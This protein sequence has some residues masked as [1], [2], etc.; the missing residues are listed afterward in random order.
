VIV[1]GGI[2]GLSAAVRLSQAGLAVTLLEASQLGGAASTRNQ[3]WLH[4]GAFYAREAPEY[5]RICHAALQQTLKFCPDC[6]EHGVP[7]MA[8]LFSRPETLVRSWTHA[9]HA[10]GIPQSE[11]PLE[12]VF[13]A[14]PGVA[15]NRV[16]HAFKLPDRAIRPD[17]LVAHLAATAQNAGVEIRAG[18]PVKRLLREGSRIEGVATAGGEEIAARMV[19]LAAGSTGFAMSAEFQSQ[20]AGSQPEVEL[21]TLKA[22]LVSFE[23]EVG[24]LPFCVPDADGFNHL[25]HPPASVFGTGRWEKA[26]HADDR[27]DPRQIELLRRRVRDFFPGL[28][29]DVLA[30]EWAGT[31]MQALQ[32]D[33]VTPGGALWPAV[34][35]HS[36]HAPHVENLLSIYSG[37]ATLWTR[38]AEQTRQAVLTKLDTTPADTAHPPWADR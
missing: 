2:S 9:W 32:V 21:M 22:H 23:Q 36:R 1:G 12:E 35:D 33:Q 27:V 4:S 31:M 17:V 30:H 11:M 24:R 28:S 25:P 20:H 10:A 5:A 29:A 26:S 13:A 3:G 8:I 14:L 18:T 19:I 37:R 34:I 38:L 15:R 6:L 16:Q 7:A